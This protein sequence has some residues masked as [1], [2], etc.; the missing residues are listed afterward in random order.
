MRPRDK[1]MSVDFALDRRTLTRASLPA[2][3]KS[4]SPYLVN[5]QV[6]CAKGCGKVTAKC[7]KCGAASK[8]KMQRSQSLAKPSLFLSNQRRSAID[9]SLDEET[10]EPVGLSIGEEERKRVKARLIEISHSVNPAL[11]TESDIHRDQLEPDASSWPPYPFRP[12]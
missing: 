4:Y 3:K 7:V 9:P 10:D 2:R 6:A 5:E 1:G 12:S 8:T 11:P